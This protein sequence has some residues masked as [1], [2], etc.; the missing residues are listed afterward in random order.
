MT[1]PNIHPRR[2][3]REGVLEVLFAQ[4]FSEEKPEIV[5]SRFL[6][7]NTTRKKNGEFI[8]FLYF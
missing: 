2:K 1:N 5:L 4:Q 8:E 7:S 3:A 6:D